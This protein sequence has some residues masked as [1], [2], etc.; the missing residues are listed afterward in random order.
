MRSFNPHLLSSV[1]TTRQLERICLSVVPVLPHS[2][3]Q[4]KGASWNQS[5]VDKN[6]ECFACAWSATSSRRVRSLWT[7]SCSQMAWCN[8]WKLL[9]PI[10]QHTSKI[11]D[12]VC[13]FRSCVNWSQD[14]KKTTCIFVDVDFSFSGIAPRH[15]TFWFVPSPSNPT[16]SSRYRINAVCTSQLGDPLDAS[17][18]VWVID[19]IWGDRCGPDEAILAAVLSGSAVVI[20]GSRLNEDNSYLDVWGKCSVQRARQNGHCGITSTHSDWDSGHVSCSCSL[21]YWLQLCGIAV[22][23]VRWLVWVFPQNDELSA[24]WQSLHCFTLSGWQKIS[25]C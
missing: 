22:C 21:S 16:K 18:C 10:A 15:L 1:N 19:L 9:L 5:C 12:Q 11:K 17:V 14:N 24:L 8:Y 7:Q 20:L 6:V 3:D 2:G 23:F 25:S 13:C 4:R